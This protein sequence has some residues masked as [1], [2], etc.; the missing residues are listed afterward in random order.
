MDVKDYIG[1]NGGA[2]NENTHLKLHAKNFN[3]GLAN[4]IVSTIKPKNTLEFGSGL[5]FLSKYIVDSG[6]SKENYCIEPNEITGVY[7]NINGPILLPID[8]FKNHHPHVI[9]KK[10]DLVLSI[11]VAEHIPKENHDFLFDFLV[12]HSSNWI[13]FSGARIG[14]GGHGHIAERDEDDWK[15][16]FLKRGMIFK[17]NETANIRMSCDEKNINHKQNLMVFKRENIYKELD[18]IEEI[19]KPYLADLLAIIQYKSNSLIGNLFYVDLNDAINAM[20]VDNLKEK[21]RTL[22]EL[23]KNKNNILEI[24][25]NAGHSALIMLLVNN[26]SK[27]T[28]IDTCE[29]Y[30]TEECFN[31]LN[32]LFPKRLKLVKGDSTKVVDELKGEKFDLIHYD[33][34]KE[35]T[36]YE[37]LKNTFK[38]VEKNHILLID[39]TQN[40]SLKEI[41]LKFEE[42]NFIDLNKY[43]EFSDRTN[44]YKWKHAI[45][46]F[47]I[48]QNDKLIGKPVYFVTFHKTASSFFSNYIL[49]QA[50]GLEHKDIASLI[51][52][53]NHLTDIELE[54]DNT[55]YGPIRLSLDEGPVYNKF[56]EPLLSQKI[57]YKYKAICFIRDPRDII[58]SFFYSQAYSHVISEQKDIKE[59]QLK[60]REYALSIGI[61]NYALEKADFLQEKFELLKNILE[62]N[63][64]SI[65]LKYED[66]IYDFDT[67]YEQIN[68]FIKLPKETKQIIYENTRP[69]N[70]GI[71]QHRRSGEQ[72]TF[73]NELK[74]ETIENINKK[75][76]SILEFFDYV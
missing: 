57:L 38:L 67:F 29:P 35:K 32:R 45:G 47:V 21:R 33:R 14:Q 16:E 18:N 73:K 70:S 72:G 64:N 10:F 41:V 42:E 74:K 3:E 50:I 69:K 62:T 76:K 71:H 43:K 19:A 63:S 68:S 39:D 46:T 13:I 55:I 4:F 60:N 53:N 52:S 6:C 54:S 49:N 15:L 25:F 59:L 51:F 7:D 24:G 1:S 12:A 11:E 2:W 17:E 22:I 56:V 9:N 34:G 65:L 37:D 30:Y 28:I 27:I 66:M 44:E 48:S 20:P 58:V 61:D 40:N 8:I 75:L 26:K 31:Y 36:I 23:T 5:G